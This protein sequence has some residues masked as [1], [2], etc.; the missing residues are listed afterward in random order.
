MAVEG[1]PES[2]PELVKCPDHPTRDVVETCM[3]CGRFLCDWC[4]KLS[5]SWGPGLCASCQRHQAPR[6]AGHWLKGWLMLAGALLLI[7]P[8]LGFKNVV[9]AIEI[10]RDS[11][12]AAQ[13]GLALVALMIE[14]GVWGVT[15]LAAVQFF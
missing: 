2:S 15:V 8:V 11:D 6:A 5:P 14:V 3:R 12:E 1:A 7:L 13:R 10:L 9:L 4:V